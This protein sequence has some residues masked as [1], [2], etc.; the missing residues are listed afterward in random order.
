MINILTNHDIDQQ[1]WQQL[2]ERSPYATWLTSRCI[3]MGGPLALNNDKAIIDDLITAYRSL[4]SLKTIYTEIRP[5]YDSAELFQHLS[6]RKWKRIG[7]YN[8]LLPLDKYVDELY[9]HRPITYFLAQK[10]YK[11]YH[12]I[13]AK[14]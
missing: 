1:Q 3:I 5:I 7:H 8:I 6:T 2:I 9:T 12:K 14:L 13:N 4:I 11:L 10:A